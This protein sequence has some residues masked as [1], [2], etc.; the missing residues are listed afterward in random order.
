M[1]MSVM[2]REVVGGDKVNMAMA[3]QVI[4]AALPLRIISCLKGP[5]LAARLVVST[6]LGP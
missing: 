2:G 6:P 5:L 4:H 1:L 3:T